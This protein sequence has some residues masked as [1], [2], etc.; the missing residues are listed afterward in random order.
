HSGQTVRNAVEMP[1]VLGERSQ[2]SRSGEPHRTVG[3]GSHGIDCV[4]SQTVLI[5]KCGEAPILDPRDAGIQSPRPNGAVGARC[6][7]EN[8]VRRKTVGLSVS[9]RLKRSVP[10]TKVG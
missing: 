2:T 9:V 8:R 3:A 1:A 6:D 10:D 7:G 5:P 4:G